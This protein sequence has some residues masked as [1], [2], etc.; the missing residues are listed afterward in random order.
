VS[1]KRVSLYFFV[2]KNDKSPPVVLFRNP[3]YNYDTVDV[4][5]FTVKIAAIDVSGIAWVKVNDSEMIADTLDTT[6]V[7]TVGLSQGKNRFAISASDRKG[8]AGTDTLTLYYEPTIADKTPP[9]I[10]ILDP[11]NDRHF[12]DTIIVVNGTATDENRVSSVQV[13]GVEAIRSYPNWSAMAFLRYGYDTI[14]VTAVDSSAS[15]N[16]AT[17]SVIVI[18]NVPARFSTTSSQLDTTV[19][20]GQVYTATVNAVH[21]ENDPI[22]FRL[23]PSSY[24]SDSLP[25][26]I[27]T[28]KTATITYRPAVTGIDS[29]AVEVKDSWNDGDTLR[30]RVNVVP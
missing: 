23:L 1:E 7:F 21:P 10:A 11:Q 13:N 14:R 29:L 19:K 25:V 24:H 6:Y 12:A 22:I 5:P 8:N 20:V 9:L 4:T 28:G 26:V 3:S 27:G 16:K 30:W 18:Q 15:R 2:D 17:D